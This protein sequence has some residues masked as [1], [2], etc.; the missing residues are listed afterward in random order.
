MRKWIIVLTAAV[1]L[2]GTGLVQAADETEKVTDMVVT[3]TRSEMPKDK[4]GGSSVTVITAEDIEAK[5]LHSVAD[6]LRSVPGLEIRAYSGLGSATTASIRGADSKNTL[7][8]I[9]GVMLNDPSSPNRGANLAH[10]TPDNIERIEV[11]RG[12]MSALYGT[13]A[14]AGVINI[15]TKKGTQAPTAFATAEGGSYNTWKLAAGTAGAVKK[16]NFSLAAAQTE[17]DGFS[18]ADADNDRIPHAG[19][20]SEDD[21]YKNTTLSGKFGVD[22]TPDFDINATVRY[23]DSGVEIDDASFNGYAGD[24]F[25]T[26]W[27]WPPQPNGLKEARNETEQLYYKFDLHNFF[28]DRKLESK[29]Y[30]Q[31]SGQEREI[32]NNDGARTNAYDGNSYEYGWQGGFNLHESFLFGVGASYFEEA[33]DTDTSLEKDSDIASFWGQGQWFYGDSFIVSGELRSDDHKEFG[34]KTTYRL[35]PSYEVIKT[36]T[37]LKASYGTGFR[38]PSLYE[39]Y[40]DPV[41]AW[42]FLG[43][44]S[45][46]NPET[47][48]GWDA[49]FEQPL[50]DRKVTA[51]ATYFSTDYDDRIIYTGAFPNSTYKNDQGVTKTKGVEAFVQWMPLAVVDFTLNYTYTSAHDPNDDRLA[52]IPLNKFTFNTKYRPTEKLH[53]NLDVYWVDERDTKS[54]NKDKY[55]NPAGALE[56]YTLV[57]IS[58][59][60]DINQHLQFYG[61]VDNVFDEYYE[62]LWSYATPGFSAYAGIKVTY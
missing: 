48:V 11:V 17:T 40:A 31:N 29:F 10:L 5:K 33:F 45:A 12:P 7:V 61:R 3:A 4:I 41:P 62:E 59:S 54:F 13:N 26:V 24:R 49:G 51:G 36:G 1:V 34:Q 6:L 47:S 8:L 52:Y 37:T 35:A 25:S 19:N 15:I 43:G 18:S 14:T 60:Y 44:N 28:F 56:A 32:Y 9:D 53:L 23:I 20:T 50:L 55:G 21:G 39:L 22:I 46:L 58:G 30:Y 2:M 42:G 16:F 38:A 27:P 57:N